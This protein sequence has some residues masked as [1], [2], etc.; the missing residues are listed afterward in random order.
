VKAY[1]LFWLPGHFAG[2][3]MLKASRESN[4]SARY[5]RT[6]CE[7]ALTSGK[8]K[9]YKALTARSPS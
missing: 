8:V 4:S 1:V 9:R 7:A 2:E 5:L 3:Y 6:A